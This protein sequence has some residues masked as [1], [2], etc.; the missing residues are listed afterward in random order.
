M[1]AR[2]ATI[3]DLDAARPGV[4]GRDTRDHDELTEVFAYNP[5]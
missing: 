1:V 2:V 3:H 5:Q 4:D